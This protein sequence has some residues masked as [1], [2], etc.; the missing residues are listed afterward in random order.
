MVLL[1][2]WGVVLWLSTRA[3]PPTLAPPAAVANADP[4]TNPPA[5]DHEDGAGDRV[6]PW[7]RLTHHRISIEP[8]EE[9]I[10]GDYTP[11]IIRWTFT[12]TT[13]EQLEQLWIEAR[14]T[15]DQRAVLADP[16]NRTITGSGIVIAPPNDLVLSLSPDARARIYT[17]LAGFPENATQREP[18]RFRSAAID[19]WFEG[20]GVAAEYV[21]LTKRLVYRRNGT[22]F[23]CDYDLVLPRIRTTANRTLYLKTLARKSALLVSL[24]VDRATDIEELAEYWGRG[25]RAKDVK[26]LLQSLARQ[27]EPRTID[28][29]HLI[30]R[31]ARSLLYT[32]PLP[33]DDPNDANRDCHWTAFNFYK[34]QPDERFTDIEFVKQTLQRDY[35]PVAGEPQLGD[36]IMFVQP[37]GVVIHSCVYIADDIV[38]TKNGPSFA[39][40]WQ[41]AE[42]DSVLSFYSVGP[43]PLEVRRYR[44]KQN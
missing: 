27:P 33:S 12:G 37:G 26:P 9:F 40:P 14:L 5:A 10:P 2:P 17:V 18:F 21:E 36:V 1:A 4:A 35:Y 28:I 25:R 42:L 6:G 39:V 23:F 24:H 32:Y 30:P 19:E 31:F 20:S 15:A 16:R 41:L 13:A 38:F 34:E 3:A 8:P 11:P 7:G 43:E 44:P 22:A 29:V